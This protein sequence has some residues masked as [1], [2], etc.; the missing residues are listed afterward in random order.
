MLND[1]IAAVSTSLIAP[2]AISVIR[3]SGDETFE[4]LKKIFNNVLN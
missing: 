4:I 1:T 2:G 3:M